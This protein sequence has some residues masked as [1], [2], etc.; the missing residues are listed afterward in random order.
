M[1]SELELTYSSQAAQAE[2]A[3]C[4]VLVLG[5]TQLVSA[6]ARRGCGYGPKVI[7]YDLILL[8]GWEE[9]SPFHG[10]GIPSV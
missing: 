5:R 4:T 10:K 3:L 1:F 8:L 9:G 6:A 7:L 2:L